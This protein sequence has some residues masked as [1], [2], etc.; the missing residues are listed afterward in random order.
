[1]N[2]RAILLILVRLVAFAAVAEAL[3]IW[4]F[5]QSPWTP[6]KR[7]Y[8]PAYFASSFP[9]VG[10]SMVEVQWIWKVGRHQKRQ[11]ATDDDA[12]DSADGTGVA[13][14]QSA[15]DA[16]W[17]TLV[18]GPQQEVSAD[19]LRP[20]LSNLAFEG[21]SLWELLLFPEL[22]ALAAMCVALGVWFLV[23]GFLRALIADYAWRR[24]V[25]SRR[26]LVSTLSNDCAALAQRVCSGLAALYRTGSRHIETHTVATSTK[27]VQIQPP[28]KPAS[29]AFPLFGVYN[30][31][32]RVSA[33]AIG[34]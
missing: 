33:G 1:M 24:R 3:A 18:K 25:Y 22:S 29:F 20:Y 9:F 27:T 21:Q 31:A 17:K 30:G 34:D 16:G 12:V 4:A 23:I 5:W 8:L 10:P 28:A 13:L 14:S 7:H 11:L 26:E 2:R 6:I 19:E 32:G 15:V